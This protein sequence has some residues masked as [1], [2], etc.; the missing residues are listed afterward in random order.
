M[1]VFLML[2]DVRRNVGAWWGTGECRNHL[3]RRRS[4]WV[5]SLAVK[6]LFYM[7]A[8]QLAEFVENKWF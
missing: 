2:Q 7:S 5:L 8:V 3:E 1:L 4:L 6:S